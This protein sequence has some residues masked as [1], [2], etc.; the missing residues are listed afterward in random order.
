MGL[1][2]AGVIGLILGLLQPWR[3]CA[4]DTVAAACPAT[5]LE[6]GLMLGAMAVGIAGFV[7]MFIALRRS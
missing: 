4:D 5:S 1:M 2:A 3:T 7:V 6:L